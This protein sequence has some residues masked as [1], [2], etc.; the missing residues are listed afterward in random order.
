MTLENTT[1]PQALRILDKE[2][3]LPHLDELAGRFAGFEFNDG[4]KGIERDLELS[5]WEMV[6]LAERSESQAPITRLFHR[7]LSQMEC[8][9]HRARSTGEQ[10]EFWNPLESTFES[11]Q[12]NRQVRCY[13]TESGYPARD[14]VRKWCEQRLS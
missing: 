11:F 6:T 14:V 2:Q 1:I 8:W 12:K 10:P 3:W 7:R 13:M 5:V 9:L 4:E